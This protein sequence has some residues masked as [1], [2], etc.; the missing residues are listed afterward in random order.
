[1]I[2]GMS[3]WILSIVGVAFLNIMVDTILP[4]NRMREIVKLAISIVL[5]YTIISPILHLNISSLLSKLEI[6]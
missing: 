1:M 2:S 4:T 3:S 5:I 6:F